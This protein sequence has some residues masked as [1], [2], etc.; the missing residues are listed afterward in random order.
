MHALTTLR[1]LALVALSA[2]AASGC[3]RS[4][5]VAWWQAPAADIG[6]AQRVVITDAYGREDAVDTTATQARDYI[7]AHGYFSATDRQHRTRLEVGRRGDV[8][9]DTHE[10][11]E[12]DA[13][14]LRID[15]L[16]YSAF[17]AETVTDDGQSV[18]V[19]ENTTAHALLSITAADA[20]GLIIEEL[21]VEGIAEQAGALTD[22]DVAALLDTATQSALR[23]GLTDL[24]PVR[25][26]DRVPL[27]DRDQALHTIL[28]AHAAPDT[29]VERLTAFLH[30]HPE[31]AGALYNR[32]AHKEA[33]GDFEGALVDYDAAMDRDASQQM[34]VESHAACR[35]RMDASRRLGR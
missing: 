28:D 4:V 1:P 21:E 34:Y 31:H 2:F 23:E 19:S 33:R 18:T 29:K 11:M 10:A 12:A 17:T 20:H 35:E 26:T 15:V 14:Y 5:D 16:E 24:L 9:L 8:W 27:D 3:G 13:I 22:D 30:E 6:T 25:R 7:L 32:G